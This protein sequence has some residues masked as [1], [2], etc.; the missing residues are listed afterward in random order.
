MAGGRP[1]VGLLGGIVAPWLRKGHRDEAK[2]LFGKS[3]NG[4]IV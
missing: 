2:I 3:L 1:G 4:F